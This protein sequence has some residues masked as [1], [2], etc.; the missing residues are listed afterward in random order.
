MLCLVAFYCAVVEK[1]NVYLY[2]K[3]CHVDQYLCLVYIGVD[4]DS[5]H[6]R[7]RRDVL[8]ENAVKFYQALK[9]N[10][11]KFM[12]F[13]DGFEYEEI[14]SDFRGFRGLTTPMTVELNSKES[15]YTDELIYPSWERN[16][17]IQLGRRIFNYSDDEINQKYYYSGG[18]VRQF[19]KPIDDLSVRIRNAVTRARDLE[20]KQSLFSKLI[21]ATG[22][23]IDFIVQ[24]FISD[25][26]NI[27]SY[28][29]FTDW[30]QII[31]SE[32]A[33]TKLSNFLL[34]LNIYNIY[35]WAKRTDPDSPLVVRL[36]G[37]LIHHLASNNILNIFIKRNPTDYN[38]GYIQVSMKEGKALH[39]GTTQ[40][41]FDYLE[42]FRVNDDYTYWFPDD[43][44]EFPNID[45]I[46]KIVFPSTKK[47]RIAYVKITTMA[48]STRNNNKFD[49][50]HFKVMNTIFYR[51]N[52]PLPIFITQCPH[53]ETVDSFQL[54]QY[55][56]IAQA[57]QEKCQSFVGYNDV[58]ELYYNEDGTVELPR[59]NLYCDSVQTSKKAKH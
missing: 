21:R 1:K 41:Y 23:Q 52:A 55:L 34:P 36:Y 48:T 19:I 47:E 57:V 50:E 27:N 43:K 5:F 6:Y 45:F 37:M 59:F 12:A 28:E 25:K 18:S 14:R 7:S 17:I 58:S 9:H 44:E 42:T 11:Y 16:Q 56:P 26:E 53:V 24:T 3:L 15:E 38:N 33:I 2:R 20:N 4:G 54:E 35:S 13:L 10:N 40:D 39:G 32:Y 22:Y 8:D 30:E 49:E 29:D 31:D 46:T 51:A